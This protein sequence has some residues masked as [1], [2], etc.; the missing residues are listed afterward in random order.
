[1]TT[2]DDFSDSPIQ[3]SKEMQFVITMANLLKYERCPVLLSLAVA[4]ACLESSF[5]RKSFHNNIYGIK[6]HPGVKC[7]DAKTKEVVD[8][9]YKDFKLAFAVY[10]SI[11]DCIADYNRIMSYYRYKPVREA[12]DYKEACRQVKACGYATGK[13]YDINLIKLI[14]R[15]KL[16]ELD[17]NMQPDD[18]I[19][20]NF[21]FKEFFSNDISGIKVAPLEF[22]LDNIK[23]IAKQLQLVRNYYKLPIKINSAYRTRDW[24]E[25]IGGKPNSLHLLGLAAD[26]KPLWHIS[27]DEFYKKIKELTTFKGYGLSVNWIHL[28]IRKDFTVW[29]Y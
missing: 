24:N 8:G 14:E 16:Y 12:K 10:D 19:T 7:M 9:E 28:D 17:F 2:E 23:T 26:I 25:R 15:Y 3:P 1:M 18:Y 21:K 4:Q 29:I 11:G 5:S 13:L 22:L 27:I 6:C 20:H